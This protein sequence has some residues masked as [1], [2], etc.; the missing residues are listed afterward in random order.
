MD[1]SLFIKL[2]LLFLVFGWLPGY[3]LLRVFRISPA[4][5]WSTFVFL[6]FIFGIPLTSIV[7]L[8]VRLSGFVHLIW[9]LPLGCLVVCLVWLGRKS[10]SIPSP[11]LTKTQGRDFVLF[12]L[13]FSAMIFFYASYASRTYMDSKG[14]L[15]IGDGAYSDHI[16]SITVAAE[17]KHHVPPRLAILSGYRMR[18]HYVG[19]LFTDLLY[20]MTAAPVSSLEFNFKYQPPFYLFFLFGTLYLTARYCFGRSSVAF[21]TIILFAFAPFRSYLIYK[22]HSTMTIIYFYVAAFFLLTAYF[23]KREKKNYLWGAFFLFG[24]LP[25]YDASFGLVTNGTLF[26]YGLVESFRMKRFSPLLV[27]TLGAI[28]FGGAVYITA[29]GWPASHAG[30]L[31]FGKGPVM[32]AARERYKWITRVLKFMLNSLPG[33]QTLIGKI[34]VECTKGIYHTIFLILSLFLPPKDAYL[35]YHFLSLPLLYS[36]LR[37]PRQ[38]DRVWNIVAWISVTAIFFSTLFAYKHGPAISV[39]I[40]P[41]ELVQLILIPFTALVALALWKKR[42]WWGKALLGLVFLVYVVPGY[43]RFAFYVKSYFYS[44]VDRETLEVFNYLKEKTPIAS[45]VLHPIHDNP[46]YRV[47]EPPEKPAW[48]FQGHYFFVSAL[49]ERQAVFEGAATSTT[50]YMGDASYDE[51]VAR[52]KEVDEF[53]TTKDLDW[54]RSFLKRYQVNYVWMPEGHPLQFAVSALLQPVVQNSKHTLFEV[55]AL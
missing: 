22:H 38:F 23:R 44:Y 31:W 28:V 4:T 1:L 43:I 37:K 10:F 47:G 55:K 15:V 48:M 27:A 17:L 32:A 18:Y 40:R 51:V 3:V 16:W 13:L 19:E 24:I 8:F 35:K 39:T 49:A 2:A 54:A 29:L 11:A 26:L 7:Y 50:Y 53:Y 41:I 36:V 34:L 25:L 52:M 9:G 20:R 42:V 6:P 12:S 33:S 45:V 14:G 5:S 21:L 30:S 46:I